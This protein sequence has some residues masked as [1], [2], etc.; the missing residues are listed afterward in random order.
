MKGEV[1]LLTFLSTDIND[2]W[3][4]RQSA[5]LTTLRGDANTTHGSSPLVPG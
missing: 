2:N 4:G 1:L 5:P 3:R